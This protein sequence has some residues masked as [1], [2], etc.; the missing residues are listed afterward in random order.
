M[1]VEVRLF[2]SLRQRAD[3][4]SVEIELADGACVRDAIKEVSR[5]PGL[6]APIDKLKIVMAVNR[7]Y[8]HMDVVLHEGDELAL[9]PPVSGGAK[10]ADV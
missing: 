1:I 6:R 8:A 5:R 7:E 3:A 2:A 9:I 4:D 10:V